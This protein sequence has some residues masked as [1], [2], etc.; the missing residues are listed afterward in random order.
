MDILLSLLTNEQV[1]NLLTNLIVSGAGIVLGKIG[2]DHR[3]E[4]LRNKAKDAIMAGV[5]ELRPA[6]VQLKRANTDHKLT[7]E[8]REEVKQKALE[9]AIAIGKDIGV[10]IVKILGPSVAASV[11]E[12]TVRQVRT[13][14]TNIMKPEVEDLLPS[15][16]SPK[17]TG[18]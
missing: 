18:E 8:Q 6:V 4:L 13:P 16:L 10:D 12:Q 11:L 15:P 5:L 14:S 9:Q 1:F 3:N 2:L 7:Q 17:A